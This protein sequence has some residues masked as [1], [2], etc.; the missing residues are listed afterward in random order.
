MYI[1]FI[2]ID[3]YY[4][5][6]IFNEYPHKLLFNIKLCLA[7]VIDKSDILAPIRDLEYWQGDI[8]WTNLDYTFQN[9]NKI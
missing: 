1:S 8:H 9:N 4:S 3:R 2:Y 7:I 5:C 6:D